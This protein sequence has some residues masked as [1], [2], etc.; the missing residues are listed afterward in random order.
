LA[1]ENT[2]PS[3][4]SDAHSAYQY[5]L[6]QGTDPHKLVFAGESAGGGLVLGLAMYIR[7]HGEP[8]PA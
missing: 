7:D 5:I 2:H 6:T 8:L 4:L 3:A 1:P